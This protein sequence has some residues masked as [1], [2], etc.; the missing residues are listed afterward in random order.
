[1]F[2][3]H[4]G[5]APLLD[6]SI[7]APPILHEIRLKNAKNIVIS[8]TGQGPETPFLKPIPALNLVQMR[9]KLWYQK[10]LSKRAKYDVNNIA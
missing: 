6:N 8:Q 2:G 5:N 7:L 9:E 10:Q 4:G 1:L 3:E